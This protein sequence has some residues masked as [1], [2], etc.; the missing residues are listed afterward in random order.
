MRFELIKR[1]KYRTWRHWAEFQ[2]MKLR[3]AYAYLQLNL[4]AKA[5]Q[6]VTA[7]SQSWPEE[8]AELL[9]QATGNAE[10]PD[11]ELGR[12]AAKRFDRLRAQFPMLDFEPK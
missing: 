10:P 12:A 2:D 5:W 6:P 8:K 11:K 9:K 1:D 4:S 3:V 7:E